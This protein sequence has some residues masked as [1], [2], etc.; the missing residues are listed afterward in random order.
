MPPVATGQQSRPQRPPLPAGAGTASID[1][2]STPHAAA[3]VRAEQRRV[4]A[5]APSAA[6]ISCGTGP[7]YAGGEFLA[8]CGRT[9]VVEYHRAAEHE[10]LGSNSWLSMPAPADRCA[11]FIDDA[12]SHDV[13]LPPQ[14]HDLACAELPPAAGTGPLSEGRARSGAPSSR[15]DRNCSAV[16]SDDRQVAQLAAAPPCPRSTPSPLTKPPPMPVETVT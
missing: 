2:E 12:G 3:S 16:R 11:R 13:A 8:R 1:A 5:S 9:P 6:I 7:P 15:T 4:P 14:L 10:N